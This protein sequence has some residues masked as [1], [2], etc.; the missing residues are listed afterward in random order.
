MAKKNFLKSPAER[1]VHDRAVSLRKMTDEQ[2]C[3]TMD[4]QYSLGVDEGIR[5]AQETAQKQESER[6]TISHFIDYLETRVG[7][8][9]RI[10]GGAIYA[11]RR[12]VEHKYG[13]AEE[14]V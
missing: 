7:S 10:G 9:N 14:A 8:G 3:A 4:R 13:V 12:E 11:L 1:A 6:E 2:L 5:M